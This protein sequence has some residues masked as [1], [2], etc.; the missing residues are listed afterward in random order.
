MIISDGNRSVR[1]GFASEKVV[2]APL[3][4]EVDM[5]NVVVSFSLSDKTLD[6]IH[7]AMGVLSA[8]EVAI[9]GESGKI[10]LSTFDSKN[11]TSDIYSIELGETDQAFRAVFSGDNWNFI[12]QSYEVELNPKKLA[13]FTGKDKVNINYIVAMNPVSSNFS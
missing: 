6:E 1:Y 3:D 7:K 13:R 10:S 9:V 5:S 12:P 4:K 2:K 11:Q 8:P